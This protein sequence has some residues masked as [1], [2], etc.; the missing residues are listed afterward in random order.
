MAKPVGV[1]KG[2]VQGNL[3]LEK[4]SFLLKVTMPNL[5]YLQNYLVCKVLKNLLLLLEIYLMVVLGIIGKKPLQ[6]V[7]AKQEEQDL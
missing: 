1:G 6:G 3:M 7:L 5:R 2:R 4:N